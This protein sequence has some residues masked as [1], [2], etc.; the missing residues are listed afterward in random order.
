MMADEKQAYPK[1][2]IE[3]EKNGSRRQV[4][5]FAD[6][7]GNIGITFE[8]WVN[9]RTRRPWVSL[10]SQTRLPPRAAIAT[11]KALLSIGRKLLA[12]EAANV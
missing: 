5:V 8:Q 12:K 11:G 2:E 6:V 4:C 7:G 10:G 1:V 3:Y 9:V